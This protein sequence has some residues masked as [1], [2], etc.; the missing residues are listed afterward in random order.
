MSKPLA[1][2]TALITG[3]SSGIG[4]S[5]A[6]L[7]AQEGA[8]VVVNAR[9]TEQLNALVAEIHDFGGKALAI[10]GDMSD[11]HNID[12]VLEGAINWVGGGCKCDIVVV[13]A[14]R[15]LDKGILDSDESKWEELY[16]INFFGAARLMR[17]AG[18][19]MVRKR[20]GDI[21]VVGSVVGRTVASV[22][23]VY[24]SSKL[25]IG[26]FAE[27]L[28]REIC[29]YGVRVSL[30]MPGIVRSEF[31]A[32]GGYGDAFT[33]MTD[34]MGRLLDP[35]AVGEGIRWLLALPP[36]VNVNEI[37]IRPTGQIHP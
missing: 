9:R 10:E 3:A 4:R 23:D 26:S 11:L 22:G 36:H 19:Y 15:G 14:G 13:N 6:K 28:R 12:N 5:A 20:S 7:L 34:T 25:A 1:G 2:K 31:H 16:Q 21:V 17:R 33:T 8:A 37:V 24:G 35:H 30:V 32:I 27:A 29:P 18:Q